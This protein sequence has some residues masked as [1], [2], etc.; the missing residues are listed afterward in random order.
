M[1]TNFSSGYRDTASQPI[2]SIASWT[3]VD[4]QVRYAFDPIDD[5]KYGWLVQLGV[6]NV[7]N[8][9]PPFMINSTT[10]K[11]PIHWAGS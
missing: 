5:T 2:R 9:N 1:T 4:L 7:A 3:T 6:K 8:R 10:K 11:M